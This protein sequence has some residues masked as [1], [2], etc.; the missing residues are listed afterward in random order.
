MYLKQSAI[1][2]FI[3]DFAKAFA[4]E[5]RIAI[6]DQG[7]LVFLILLPFAYPVLYSLIY[8][9]ELVRDVAVVVVDNDRTSLSRQLS[10]NLDA[11]QE[12]RVIGY[13]P[14]L[15]EAK[16]AM[17]SHDCF[18]IIE[19]PEGFQRKVGRGE[20][21]NAVFYSDMSLLIR[22]KGVLTATTNVALAMGSE[23][24]A[25]KIDETVPL[26]ATLTSGDPMPVESR[27]L[28]NIQGGFDSFLM[29]GVLI[30]ILQQATILAVG[31]A[32]GARR[33]KRLYGEGCGMSLPAWLLGRATCY[34]T[35]FLVPAI[36]ICHYVPLMF[37]FPM[38]GNTLEI[39]SFILP[40]LIASVMLG[41]CLQLFVTERESVF[42]IWVITSI[43][44]LFLSGLT[45]PRY[46]MSP[47]WKALADCVPATFGVLGFIKMNSNGSSLAQVGSCY[48]AL[49]IQAAAYTA[50]AMLIQWYL[51]RSDRKCGAI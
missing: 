20:T 4:S 42:I 3:K 6:H 16:R 46:A 25:K 32:G 27:S 35:L 26:A 14:D 50:L 43:M 15:D 31:M 8:N 5:F 21:A 41:Y 2:G 22:Y 37:S 24:Q 11:C 36:Y 49:W 39:F 34:M 7:I 38:E 13:A 18:A 12:I 9:P 44:F 51:R 29:P 17:D 23:L 45:W 1:M 48:T 28:G 33:E 40:M 47:V 19:I 10:R 30:L